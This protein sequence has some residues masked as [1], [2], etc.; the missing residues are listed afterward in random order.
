M[1]L[2]WIFDMRISQSSYFRIRSD[3]FQIRKIFW[4]WFYGLKHGVVCRWFPKLWRNLL[5][6]SSGDRFHQNVD[7][8]LQ[9]NNSFQPRKKYKFWISKRGFKYSWSITLL[10]I[11]KSLKSNGKCM[12]RAIQQSATVHFDCMRLVWMSAHTVIISSNSVNQLIFVTAKWCVFF[13]IQKVKQSRYTPCRRL[14]GE[15][16]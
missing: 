3:R 8:N 14:G 15:E 9:V 6:Q 2:N 11:F 16:V 12:K 7:C 4:L 13:E 1:L 10:I 5:H